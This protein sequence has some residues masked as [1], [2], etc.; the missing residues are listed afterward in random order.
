M[1]AC[2][3]RGEGRAGKGLTAAGI[4]VFRVGLSHLLWERGAGGVEAHLC[5][6]RGLRAAGCALGRVQVERRVTLAAA[7]GGARQGPVGRRGASVSGA[8]WSHLPSLSAIPC[9]LCS[10]KREATLDLELQS[11]SQVH[12]Q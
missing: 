1:E 7:A 6:L 12:P 9:S 11:Y 8:E 5:V 4:R 10:W 2:V 3:L